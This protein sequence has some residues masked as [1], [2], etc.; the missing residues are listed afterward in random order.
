MKEE[1]DFNELWS[2]QTSSPPPIDELL[3]E[4]TKMN[5][6][7]RIKLILINFLM[8]ATIAFIIFILLYFKPDLITTKIGIVVTIL[9]ILIYQFAYNRLFRYLKPINENQKNSDFLAALIER[10]EKQKFLQTKMLQFYFLSF[11]VGLC[12]YLYE[13]VVL[14]PFPWSIFAYVVTLIWIGFNWFYLRP[15]IIQKEQTK[16]D[17]MIQQFEKVN[18]QNLG[19]I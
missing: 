9:S 12:L 11:S 6:K 19:L 7:E 18:Q 5:S 1:N 8:I 15:R 2:K 3:S 13:Y 16:I 4:L 17:A 14:M 10:K